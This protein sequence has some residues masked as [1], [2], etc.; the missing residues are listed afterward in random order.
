MREKLAENR[1]VVSGDFFDK[2]GA[3]SRLLREWNSVHNLSGAKDDRAIENHIFDSVFPLSFLGEFLDD[4][5]SAI[6]I[7]SGAGF[8]ALI[9]AMA[10]PSAKFT[11]VEPIA[12][13]ASFLQFAAISIG[14][15]NA[16]VIDGRIEQV[17]IAKYDLITSRAVS[18]AKTIYDL[19]LPFMDSSTILLLYKGKNTAK[20]AESIGAQIVSAPHAE[21]L[22]KRG[23]KWER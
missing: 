23:E 15:K 19:A 8:P 5:E 4:F 3:F 2:V 17:A 7:G 12:K 14:I 18:D 6:D 9:L 16:I 22:V 21:Y 11:L 20:E 10:K 13:K 1:V